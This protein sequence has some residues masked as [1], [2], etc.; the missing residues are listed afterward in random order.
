MKAQI[1]ENQDGTIAG[2]FLSIEDWNSIKKRFSGLEIVE[3]NI[4]QWQIDLLDYRLKDIE[5]PDKLRDVEELL[6]F[7]DEEV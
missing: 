3:E 2:V 4:P 7:L 1:I 5:N 6:L